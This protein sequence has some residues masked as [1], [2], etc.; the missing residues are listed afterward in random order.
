[1][2]DRRIGACGV[3]LELLAQ[4]AQHQP[5]REQT[6][7]CDRR[8]RAWG[9]APALETP[10]GPSR[11]AEITDADAA[12]QEGVERARVGSDRRRCTNHALYQLARRREIADCAVAL[13]EMALTCAVSTRK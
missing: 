7:V 11:G 3:R 13:R 4:L 8:R 1:M 6:A 12:T 10:E 2:G 9:H 5:L